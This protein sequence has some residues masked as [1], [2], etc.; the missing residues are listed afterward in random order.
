MESPTPIQDIRFP[1]IG[2]KR[3][4]PIIEP[5]RKTDD[6]ENKENMNKADSYLERKDD[7]GEKFKEEGEYV[8]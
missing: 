4:S 6:E 1:S 2:R 3:K 8:E 7:Q 5:G